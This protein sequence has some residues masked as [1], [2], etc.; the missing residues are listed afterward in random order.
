MSTELMLAPGEYEGRDGEILRSSD[1]VSVAPSA[2]ESMTR[3]EIDVQITTAKKFPRNIKRFLSETQTL[4][5]LNTDVASSCI[6]ALP[7]GR[8]AQN[9]PK[10]IEGPSVRFAE[11]ALSCWGNSRVAS[12]VIDIGKDEVTAMAVGLDL[13]RNVGCSI[14]AKRS[15]LDRNGRRYKAD[16]ILVTGQAAQSI[17]FRNAVWKIVPG[18]FINP[19]Y[20]QCRMLAAGEGMSVEQR[21]DNVLKWLKLISVSPDE[22]FAFLQVSSIEDLTIEHMAVIAGIK[23]AIREGETTVDQVFRSEKAHSHTA[24]LGLAAPSKQDALAAALKTAAE[25]KAKAAEQLG[26][27]PEHPVVAAALVEPERPTLDEC[28][29]AMADS[30]PPWQEG[31]RKVERPGPPVDTRTFAP[32]TDRKPRSQAKRSDMFPP[33]EPGSNG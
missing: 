30:T 32:A 8:D 3:A 12:R 24:T 28:K 10:F 2:L 19:I 17:A 26:A 1:I 31:A 7:R 25:A 13:E 16:M 20:H 23:S 29:A 33:D 9:K 5:T 4:A 6:Y 27:V 22:L 18:A 15:I 14:E 11:I 21:R